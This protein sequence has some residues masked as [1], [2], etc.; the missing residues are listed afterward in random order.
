M[1][2]SVVRF[3]PGIDPLFWLLTLSAVGCQAPSEEP[4]PESGD[5]SLEIIALES[6]VFGNTR[7]LRVW[8]PPGY[9]DPA[10]SDR[11]YPVLFLNDGQNLFDSATALFG[12]KEWQVDEIATALLEAGRISPIV[13]V[14]IDNAGRSGRAREYL[15]FPDAF[16]DP[17][18][19]NPQGSLYGEF[20]AEE[21]IPFVESHFRI[22][23]D[24][25]VLGGSSYGALV[26][27]HVAISRP[28]LFTGLLLESPSFYVDDNHILEEAAAGDLEL[29]RVYIGVGTN[30]LAFDG[31]PEHPGNEEAVEG[32]RRMASILQDAGL[33]DGSQL[34][35]TI[36][37]CAEHDEDAWAGR[38]P[39]AL[40]F[41]FPP[42]AAS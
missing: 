4:G 38:L 31:C 27:M 25:R 35:V 33:R 3:L 24:G 16:L 34:V 15:P 20:L 37:E 29:D 22:R 19:P 39:T 11:F 6:R 23:G 2:P 9:H 26:S 30:E 13:V 10:S 32:V 5:L 1:N 42:G 41:L 12:S 7:N 17:P 8:L 36:E 18:E 28:G 21:V 40:S 14:G